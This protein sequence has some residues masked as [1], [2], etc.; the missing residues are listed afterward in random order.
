MS[1]PYA[2][3]HSPLFGR[4]ASVV[5][6]RR[7]VGDRADLEADCIECAHRGLASRARALDAHFDILYAAFLRGAT[8]ALRCDLRRERSGLARALEAGVARGRPSE[9]VALAIGDRHDRVV[10]RRVDMRDTFRDVL[11]DLFARAGGSGLLQLLARRC[12]SGPHLCGLPCWYVEFHRGLARTL[13]R[14]RV[15]ARAL[16][17]HGQSLAMAHA[18]IAAEIHQALDRHGDFTPQ[19]ALDR[20]LGDRFADAIEL[21]VVQILDLA[22]ALH[23]GG[24]ADRLRARASDAIDRGQ[25]D[26][27]VLVVGD[28]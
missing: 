1:N 26:I 21:A 28:V 17:P 24:R 5:R 8:A 22:V 10:E 11:L 20:E 4:A 13:A 6:N 23:A 27:G 14:A 18:A 19:I 3:L 12:G 9:R 2:P 16:P 7:H 25:R 15:G